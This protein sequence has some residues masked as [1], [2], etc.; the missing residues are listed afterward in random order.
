MIA[1]IGANMSVETIT[2]STPTDSEGFVLLECDLCGSFFKLIP[3]DYEDEKVLNIWCPECGLQA[4]NYLTE[5]VVNLALIK[6]QNMLVDHI[7]D[8]I[9]TLERKTKGKAV[10]FKAGRRP[11]HIKEDPVMYSID[12]LEVVHYPCCNK[13]AKISPLSKLVGSYCPF[14]GVRNG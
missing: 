2:L 10:R 4:E 8:E 1:S 5:E 11:K 6:G 3:E 14:C 7:Y 13:S 9:K 12:S